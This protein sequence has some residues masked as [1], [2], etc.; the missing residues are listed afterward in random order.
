MSIN[1]AES[2]SIK[3]PINKD[4]YK[5]AKDNNRL[6]KEFRE[7]IM[8]VAF[9]EKP[10]KIIEINDVKDIVGIMNNFINK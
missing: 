5:L 3:I 8:L 6:L 1:K 2:K 7:Q 4:I 10:E 9:P